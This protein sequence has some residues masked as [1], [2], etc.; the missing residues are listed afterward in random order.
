LNHQYCVVDCGCISDGATGSTAGETGDN[1]SVILEITN[2][3]K[4]VSYSDFRKI[5]LRSFFE[6]PVG[7]EFNCN[8][9]DVQAPPVPQ[10]KAISVNATNVDTADW[11]TDSNYIVNS[12]SNSREIFVNV[13]GVT[14]ETGSS[15]GL[16]S[17]LYLSYYSAISMWAD[18]FIVDQTGKE[19]PMASV[20]PMPTSATSVKIT[21][22]FINPSAPNSEPGAVT[23]GRGTLGA[24]FKYEGT[25]IANSNCIYRLKL[26]FRNVSNAVVPGSTTVK[27]F[28]YQLT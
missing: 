13:E 15:A 25:Q 22:P 6:M 8:N 28:N 18:L 5:T 3:G 9:Q 14:V 21:Y 26:Y 17:L 4:K 19:Y 2:P 16:S 11:S 27:E 20:G 10:V 23:V 12:Y 1:G 7:P 24:P